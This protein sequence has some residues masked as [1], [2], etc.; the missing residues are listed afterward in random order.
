MRHL[1]EG[2]V[3]AA[4]FHRLLP[5]GKQL[6]VAGMRRPST[7]TLAQARKV[8]AEMLGDMRKTFDELQDAGERDAMKA[9]IAAVST[10][11]Q[12]EEDALLIEANQAADGSDW[13]NALDGLDRHDCF[14]DGYVA[15]ALRDPARY[16]KS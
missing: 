15:G 14:V 7:M 13:D 6:G 5:S 3:H 10:L 1:I 12:P 16:A 9:R 11:L 8:V 4:V 2:I